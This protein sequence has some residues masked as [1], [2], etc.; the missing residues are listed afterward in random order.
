METVTVADWVLPPPVAFTVMVK[1]PVE[2]LLEVFTVIVL[3]PD[4]VTEVGLKLTVSPL[5]CPEAEKV[6]EELKPPVGVTVSLEVPEELWAMVSELG[7]AVRVKFAV[8]DEV[9]VRETTVD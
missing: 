8:A 6:T 9:T 4:P 3:E 5:P 2:A 7:D 1:V